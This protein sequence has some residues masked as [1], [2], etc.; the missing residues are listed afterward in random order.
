MALLIRP[1]K[2]TVRGYLNVPEYPASW[3]KDACALRRLG[4]P[5]NIP[6]KQGYRLSLQRSLYKSGP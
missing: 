4:H 3:I 2:G 1:L 5:W 6:I